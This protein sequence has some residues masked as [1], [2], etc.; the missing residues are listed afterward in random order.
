YRFE[1]IGDLSI[2][3]G[4]AHL[5]DT[6]S[7][8]LAQGVGIVKT[9]LPMDSINFF[10]NPVTAGGREREA[11]ASGVVSSA[12][13]QSASDATSGIQFFPNPASDNLTLRTTHPANRVL[14]Y[15][16]TGRMVRS[17]DLAT[18]TGQALLWVKDLPNGAYLARVHYANGTSESKKILIQH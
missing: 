15:D 3:G 9:N 4:L 14:F 13:S 6:E 7:D 11:I 17:F 10:G 18:R 1:F 5:V 12:V 8:W 16:A 2:S